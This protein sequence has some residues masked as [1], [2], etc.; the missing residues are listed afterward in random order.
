VLTV[1]SPVFGR[2]ER[3]LRNRF[4]LPRNLLVR[5][6]LP[7]KLE[8]LPRSWSNI[9][10]HSFED[11]LDPSLTWRD[12]SWLCSITRLPVL[13]KGVVRPDDAILAVQHGAKGVIVSNHGGRQLDTS[14]ATISVLADV[15]GAVGNQCDVL[16]DGGIRRGTDVIKAL[17]L[18]AKAVLVGRPLLWGLASNGQ[19]GV[20]QT[21]EILRTEFDS[22]LALCGC[23]SI[24]E[25]TPD[26][27]RGPAFEREIKALQSAATSGE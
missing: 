10:Q 16:V 1:D 7:R 22:A 27:V 18:G 9:N 2:Q 13:V 12:V 3:N 8:R 25:I 15:A 21:L 14:P 24:A 4:E 11:H 6:L 23:R 5:N 19:A 20:E 17:A 26:L